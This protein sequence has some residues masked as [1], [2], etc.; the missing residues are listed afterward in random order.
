MLLAF[1]Y[2][3][4]TKEVNEMEATMIDA[5]I[6]QS[7]WAALSLVLIFYILKKQE[8]RDNVQFAREEKYQTI[9]TNLSDKLNMVQELRE[10]VKEIKKMIKE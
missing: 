3:G 2:I 1:L 5:A 8:Q 4:L 10:D 9:I 6:T 7:I